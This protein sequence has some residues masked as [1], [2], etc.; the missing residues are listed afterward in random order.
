MR[1]FEDI[2]AALDA[3]GIE[4]RVHNDILFVPISSELEVQFV[5]IDPH[6]PAANVY[7]ATADDHDD[8]DAVLTS[9]VFSVEDA[10]DTI[11]Q[12]VATDSIITVMR[13]LMEGADERVQDI[14]FEQDPEEEN[15]VW[16]PLT[17]GGLVR[18]DFSVEGGLPSAAVAFITVGAGF[19]NTLDHATNSFLEFAENSDLPEHEIS[20]LLEDYLDAVVDQHKEVLELGSF[21]DFDRLF[22]VIS[23][24]ADQAEA[25]E[26][27][28]GA[29]EGEDDEP[30]VYDLFGEDDDDNDDF[31][32]EYDE[33]ELGEDDTTDPVDDVDDD[34]IEA[35]AEVEDIDDPDAPNY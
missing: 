10:V 35:E 29:L 25:W 14:E 28:L 5:E 34:D 16:A 26:E 13:D 9:V 23:L 30:E 11:A 22:D 33:D 15:A 32:Y 17:D 19:G 31:F 2:A 24:A 8:F 12:N 6:M 4:S 21:V 1:F 20:R 7:I 27:Q 18:V 3:E